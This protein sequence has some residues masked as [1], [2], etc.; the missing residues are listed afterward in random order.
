VG[1]DDQLGFLLLDECGDRVDT[2]ANDEGSLGGG[3][4]FAGSTGLGT[5]AQTLLLGLLALGA[6]LVEQLEQ[7]SGCLTVQSLAELVD[8]RGNLQT[9]LKN[10]TLTLQTDV[11]GPANK[12]AQVT[13]GLDVLADAEVAGLLFEEWVHHL[14]GS[15]FLDGQRGRGHLLS[16]ALL[17]L[18]FLEDHVGVG[19][20]MSSDSRREKVRFLLSDRIPVAVNEVREGV[21]KANSDTVF[22]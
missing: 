1:N 16:D 14:L 7:L 22:S 5:G 9:L 10:S 4:G 18:D 21:C 6:V 19:Q 20:A 15:L 12:A 3:I 17:S 11:L 8:G 2:L 13:L